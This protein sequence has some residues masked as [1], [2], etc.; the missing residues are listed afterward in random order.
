MAIPGIVDDTD[1]VLVS[2]Q[3]PVL[4][5]GHVLSRDLVDLPRAVGQAFGSQRVVERQRPTSD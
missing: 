5:V 3:N 4:L 2:G 1:E